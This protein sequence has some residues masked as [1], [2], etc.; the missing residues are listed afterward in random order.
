MALVRRM[1]LRCRHMRR[2]ERHRGA[3]KKQLFHVKYPELTNFEKRFEQAFRTAGAAG[4][5]GSP[6]T[7]EVIA[8]RLVSP[9]LGWGPHRC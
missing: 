5:L 9:A 4:G 8:D 1:I 7:S 6:G 2:G 3:G